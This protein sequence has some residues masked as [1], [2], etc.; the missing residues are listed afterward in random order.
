M[1]YGVLDYGE[2][3]SPRN[4]TVGIVGTTA[5]VDS[6]RRWIDACSQGVSAKPS[7]QPHLFPRFPGFGQDG[8]FYSEAVHS[9]RDI[10]TLTTGELAALNREQDVAAYV[11]RASELFA[12]KVRLLT[13]NANVDVVL[14]APPIDMAERTINEAYGKG[15]PNFRHMLKARA[16]G[17]RRPTQIVLPMTYDPGKKLKRKR[18]ETDRR[19]QDE[20]TRAWNFFTALYY[21]AGGVPW[22]LPKSPSE[23]ETCY[24]GVSF[25]RTLE[26][27]GL[28]TSV[29]Q[30]FDERGE[31]VIVRGGTAKVS[32]HDKR[33]Y[34]EAEPAQALLASAIERYRQE[35]RHYPARVAVHKTS[36]FRDSEREG[37]EAALADR[38]IEV[39]DFVHLSDSKVRLFRQGAYPPLRGTLLEHSDAEATLYTRGSVEFYATYPGMYVPTPTLLR[40][41]G[42]ENSIQSIAEEVLALTKLNWNNTQFDGGDP[43]TVHAAR[44]VG[45]V[46]K[47]MPAEQPLEPQYRFYM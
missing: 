25:Y 28:E 43:I 22:R 44:R 33:P 45:D 4:V 36:P 14:C 12:N 42:S 46:L 47:Y 39:W 21:K 20:A 1:N 13:E 7:R 34:L 30:V 35:H 17:T 3:A 23:L 10:A 18:V 31:G 27:E 6:L 11:Q 2:A 37:F 5:T 41:H 38:Q 15:M 29:A 40:L 26:G 9:P 24:V 19:V 16:M 8:A 32:K